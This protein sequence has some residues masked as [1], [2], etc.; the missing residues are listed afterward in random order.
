MDFQKLPNEVI[1][2]IFSDLSRSDLKA[3]SLVCKELSERA[4]PFF[5][6]RI[7]FWLG[8]DDLQGYGPLLMLA[9]AFLILCYC[10]DCPQLQNP[11]AS[12]GT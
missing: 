12:S 11:I 7:A 3:L 4:T 10:A 5:L 1:G 8:P 2:F 9:F 6:S